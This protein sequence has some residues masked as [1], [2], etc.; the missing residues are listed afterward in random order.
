MVWH[1][2]CVCHC[3]WLVATYMRAASSFCTGKLMHAATNPFV[4]M[5]VAVTENDSSVSS[6]SISCGYTQPHST[7]RC[8]P[9]PNTP[10]P[11][12]SHRTVSYCS[13][14]THMLTNTASTSNSTRCAQTSPT[15]EHRAANQH[16]RARHSYLHTSESAFAR[17][18]RAPRVA[19]AKQVHEHAPVAHEPNLPRMLFHRHPFPDSTT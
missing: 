10:Q 11:R 9:H 12:R 1:S 19:M 8:L 14:S 15:G 2:E 4:R 16:G 17:R 7:S 3:L 13:A 5:V 6:L 18:Q